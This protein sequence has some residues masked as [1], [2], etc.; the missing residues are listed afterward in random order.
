MPAALSSLCPVHLLPNRHPRS[1]LGHHFSLVAARGI[2]LPLSFSR[3]VATPEN[4]SALAAVEQVADCICANRW[5]RAPNPLYLHGPTGTGKTHLI[6]ALAAVVAERCRHLIVSIVQ[7]RE[8]E[9]RSRP[10]DSKSRVSVDE[11]E[12]VRGSDLLVVEDIHQLCTR[13]GSLRSVT[14]EA[15]VQTFDEVYA[16]QRQLVFTATVG[17]GQLPHLPARL[18]SRLACGLVVA[19]EPLSPTSRLSLLEE[20]AQRRQLAIRHEV[21]AWLAEHLR[22]GIRQL[23]GAI[24]QLETLARLQKRPLDLTTVA[25]H[26]RDQAE[27]SRPTVMRIVEHVGSYFQVE[28]R[29]LQSR[30]RYQ[31]MVLPRQVSMYLARVLTN[32]SLDQIGSYFG[33]RDHST[34]LH[35]C[36]KIEQALTRD[37]VLSGAIKQ[38]HADLA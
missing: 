23:E 1:S 2:E 34:V 12:A 21:L 9:P 11:S 15:L 3:F 30:R 14:V 8:F 36:R 18:A 20:K 33:G 10:T 4:R 29:R 38:L 28:P 17:P 31:S 27:A 35:A 7:A 24:V 26:F 32:L 5:H 25:S 13:G 6:S 19:L 22:G 37:P 16:R